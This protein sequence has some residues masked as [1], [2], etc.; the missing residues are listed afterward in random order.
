MLRLVLSWIRSCGTH[1]RSTEEEIS[2]PT[3]NTAKVPK[4][5]LGKLLGAPHPP[6]G[7]FVANKDQSAIQPTGDRTVEAAF[8]RSIGLESPSIF[9]LVPIADFTL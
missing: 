7:T 6:L 1:S 2:L 3:E 5:L 8:S 9:L 4:L